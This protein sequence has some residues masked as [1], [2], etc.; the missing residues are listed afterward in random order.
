MRS[1]YQRDIYRKMKYRFIIFISLALVLGNC[2]P[3][4][5]QTTSV[6]L[7]TEKSNL[8]GLSKNEGI[9]S[10]P[11][12][13][14]DYNSPDFTF[15]LDSNL[16]E[17]SGLSYDLSDNTLIAVD[18]ES[19]KYFHLNP[20][21]GKVTNK[22]RFHRDGDYEAIAYNDSKVIIAKSSGNLY[23]KEKNVVKTK[24][25]K[26]KFKSRNDVEGL[27]FLPESNTLLVACKGS[28]LDENDKENI[29]C[30][31]K[32]SLTDSL[33]EEQPYLSI[34]RNELKQFIT[35]RFS[36]H[37]IISKAKMTNRIKDFAPSGIAVHPDSQDLY[38]LSARGSTLVIYDKELKLT[39]IIFLNAKTIPQ[40]EGICFDNENNLY[41]ST[42]GQVLS[43]KIFKYLAK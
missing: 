22:I 12:G 14:F 43:A 26:N 29:K 18:D 10:D 34:D 3:A 1:K 37:S 8:E 11:D 36:K 9:R 24:V 41:I 13:A 15:V 7:D 21:D 40:P 6:N 39:D 35:D 19:G 28:T 16:R 27:A 5:K 32:F 20:I 4:T 33:L 2:K 17:I 23:V 31:Y 25:Y 42:E 30:I 38:I